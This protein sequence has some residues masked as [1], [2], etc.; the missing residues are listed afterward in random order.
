MGRLA[1]GEPLA[2]SLFS[3]PISSQVSPTQITEICFC[4]FTSANPNSLVGYLTWLAKAGLN[5]TQG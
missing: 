1:Q 2:L 5:M 4:N 3:I